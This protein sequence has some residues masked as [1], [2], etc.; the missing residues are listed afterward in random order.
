MDDSLPLVTINGSAGTGKT[1][2][3]LAAGL[4]KVQEGIYS[5]ILVARPVMPLGT[6]DLGFLPGSA[7]EK[8]DPWMS[9]VYD[10]LDIIF[11]SKD[12]RKNVGQNGYKGLIEQGLLQVEPLSFIRG[13]SIPRQVFIIDEA[14][15]LSTLELKTIITRAGEGTKI[16][17][18]GDCQ[19]CDSPYM[20]ES[21][22]GLSRIVESFKSEKLAGH[23]T[24]T[25]GERSPLS[26]LAA[27][28]L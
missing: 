8:L 13:R 17:L 12:V 26:E 3:S 7:Q 22:N 15:N 9:P 16:I 2:L 5:R 14:Q 19:Q 20:D 28:I 23:I 6:Q 27:R 18:I 1:L 25:K 21:S 10:N 4:A 24:L 11:G